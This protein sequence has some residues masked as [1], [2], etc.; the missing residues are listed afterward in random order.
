MHTDA[1]S[2]AE[3]RRPSS[4]SEKQHHSAC[5]FTGP[6]AEQCHHAL[7]APGRGEPS[8]SIPSLVSMTLVTQRGCLPHFLFLPSLDNPHTDR[9][10]CLGPSGV[11][12]TRYAAGKR[13]LSH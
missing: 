10:C 11:K 9:L 2:G 5:L 3:T 7:A 4:C 12:R 6:R 8:F 1:S 13:L